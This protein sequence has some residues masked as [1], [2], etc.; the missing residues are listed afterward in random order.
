MPGHHIVAGV[1][2]PSNTL[3][4]GSGPDPSLI[5]SLKL[6]NADRP[7]TIA[8]RSLPQLFI[9]GNCLVLHDVTENRDIALPTMDINWSTAPQIELVPEMAGKFTTLKPDERHDIIVTSFRPQGI[10]RKGAQ[11]A[12]PASTTARYAASMVGMHLLVPERS[13]TIKVRNDI[14]VSSWMEG[15]FEELIQTRQQWRPAQSEI[16]V[17]SAEGFHFNVKD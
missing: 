13:Y 15:S 3:S 16:A 7:I 1:R 10:R 14:R 11:D 17:V 4:F 12:N 2:L 5:V 9:P 8:N 6:E